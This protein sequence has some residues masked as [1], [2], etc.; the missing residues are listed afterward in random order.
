VTNVG[1]DGTVFF[2]ADDGSGQELWK[3]DGTEAGT[4]RI[5][6]INPGVGESFPLDLVNVN[7]TLLSTPVTAAVGLS[8][9]RAMGK[10]RKPSYLQIL[11]RDLRLHLLGASRFL[12]KT[13]FPERMTA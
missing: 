2:T 4:V 10:K 13:F 9:G 1:A 8:C 11:L 5:K 6:D 3:S 7:G 12:A